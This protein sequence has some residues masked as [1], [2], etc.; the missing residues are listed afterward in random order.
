VLNGL[1]Q[2]DEKLI[3]PV[4]NVTV[5][6]LASRLNGCDFALDLN[7]PQLISI[8][9]NIGVGKTTLA[10]ELKKNLICDI[11]F[12]PYDE[13]PFLPDVYAGKNELA[14]DS[15]LF[16][17]V[18]RA[19]QLGQSN[20]VPGQI[21]V[22][23][24]VFDKELIYARA[25]LNEKQLG[26]YEDIYKPFS[27]IVAIPGLVIYMQDSIQNCLDRIHSR[28]RP[29]EQQIELQFLEILNNS[30]EKLFN[31]WKNSPVI[32]ILTTELDYYNQIEFESLLNQI[33]CYIAV[34]K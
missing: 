11:L 23:D 4:L 2:L 19:R 10:K 20:L 24:Y 18:N 26:L 1:C 27:D 13:N 17:L 32:R 16:F 31:G 28:N 6:E 5:R 9:G 29:Y 3:H 15:Q 22:S 7:K 8:A 34:N 25:L 33:K 14:L 21:Y 12:E 30:Y